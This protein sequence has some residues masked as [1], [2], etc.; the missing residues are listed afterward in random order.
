M[1]TSFLRGG[2]FQSPFSETSTE[3][4]RHV[5]NPS[6]IDP[7][8]R[9]IW[10]LV[11]ACISV[12]LASPSSGAEVDARLSSGQAYVNDSIDLQITIEDAETYEPPKIPTVDGLTIESAGVPRRSSQTTIING[13]MSSRQSVTLV[14]EITPTRPG[15]FEIPPMEVSVD[16]RLVKTSPLGFVAS[17]SETGDLMLV[18]IVGKQDRVYVGEP[19]ELTLKIWVRPYRDETLDRLLSEGEMWQMLSDRTSWG[20]FEPAMTDMAQQRKRPGGENVV[21]KT[22]EG[23][24]KGYYLYEIDTTIYPNKPG[25][26]DASNVLIAMNYPL[27][28]RIEKRRSMFDEAFGGQFG[29]PF[30][31]RFDSAMSSRLVVAATRPIAATAEVDQTQVVPIPREGRPASFQGA[32]GRYEMIA[33]TD[34]RRVSAGDPITLQ[35]GVSGDGPLDSVQAPPLDHLR[36]KFRIDGQ[37]LAGFIQNG[38][39]YFTTTIRPIDET[40]DSIPSIEMSFFDPKTETFETIQTEPIAIKVEEAER[41]AMDSIVG[42]EDRSES[43]TSSDEPLAVSSPSSLQDWSPFRWLLANESGPVVLQNQQRGSLK[44]IVWLVYGLPLVIGLIATLVRHRG[45]LP[46]MFQRLR[47]AKQF[48]ANQLGDVS[49]PNEIPAI[50]QTYVQRS[51]GLRPDVDWHR[52]LGVLRSHGYSDKAAELESL[53]HRCH[54]TATTTINENDQRRSLIDD[55]QQWLE[56]IA[57]AQSNNRFVFKRRQASSHEL[58]SALGTVRRSVA[59]MALFALASWNL[60][61]NLWAA[62]SVV[63]LDEAQQA[64]V[65]NEADQAYHAASQWKSQGDVGRAR[66]SYLDA[67]KRYQM[68]IDSGIDNGAIHKNLGNVYFQV[69]QL[70]RSVAHY[71]IAQTFTPWDVRNQANLII[72]QARLGLGFRHWFM[73][74]AWLVVG[75][76]LWWLGWW[77]LAGSRKDS[78]RRWWLSALMLVVSI[79]CCIVTLDQVEPRSGLAISV[80]DTLELR[81]GDGESFGVVNEL[82]G[83]EGRSFVIGQQ[84]GDWCLIEG[85]TSQSGWARRDDL[86]PI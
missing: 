2:D 34:L 40:V 61:P 62:T 41:L 69:D 49:T 82:A 21:R 66:T 12:T 52:C 46:L 4:R 59:P 81:G 8:M 16:G 54:N 11:L 68:L 77:R 84:R 29:S 6:L 55:A 85:T 28:L 19:L 50:L 33:K 74:L 51:F 45:H 60:M 36:E 76:L 58:G 65:L 79:G 47:P 44:G 56:T 5:K 26:I 22:P 15:T 63:L 14:Y 20:P 53:A 13:R 32:V 7:T 83:V 17:V 78:G 86:V 9:R 10:M 23:E 72:A 75:G 71:R 39:K 31:D 30:G 73:P 1:L 27:E 24:S 38:V 48:A 67:A 25:K 80:V 64:T 18:E 3:N 42:P 37:P 35:L 43:T 57:A 70:G